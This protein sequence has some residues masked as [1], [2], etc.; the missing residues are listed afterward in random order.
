VE[1]NRAFTAQFR[2]YDRL[3]TLENLN[4]MPEDK[5]FDDYLNPESLV[6][7]DGCKLEPSL[8]EARPGDRFQFVRTG[9]FC[10]DSRY[11]DSFNR[12]VPLKDSFSKQ[13]GL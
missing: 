3:F 11:R 1:A 10:A 13:A 2:L 12:I 5:N 6:V 4:D 9:Y 7:L 8:R